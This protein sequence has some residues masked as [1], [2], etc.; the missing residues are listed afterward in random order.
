MS[1]KN[2]QTNQ[3]RDD[4]APGL[5]V[6]MRLMSLLWPKGE[7]ALKA[8]VVGALLLIVVGKGISVV[9]PFIYKHVIDSLNTAPVYAP[10]ALIVAYGVADALNQLTGELREYLFVTVSQRAIRIT[11]LDVFQKLHALSLRFHLNRRTGGVAT[12]IA[13]GTTGI[14]FLLELALFSIFPT[15]VELALVS[16]ILLRLYDPSFA[17]IIILTI[18]A[19]LG[20]TLAMTQWQVR[21]RKEMN[22]LDVAASMKA[23]DSLLNYETVKYFTAEKAEAQRFDAA[24]SAYERSAIRNQKVQVL[25]NAGR[26]LI[27]ATG[28]MS[29]MVLAGRR[30]AEGAMTVGD[31]V[32]VNAYLL[33]LYVPLQALSLVYTQIKQ[34]LADVEAMMGLLSEKPE[35]EDVPNSPGL[36]VDQGGI[37]FRNVSFH[38][39]ERR[40]L[41]RDI[42]FEIPSGKT[43]AIVGA[44]G[45]GKSTIARLL[46]RFYDVNAGEIQLDGHDIRTVTQDSL[47]NAIGV[48]PQDTV[49]FHDTLFYNIAYGKFGA[50]RQ[51]VEH[52]A[53]AAQLDQLIARLPDG[54]DTHVGERGMKL[55]GGEKQRVAIARVILKNPRVLIFD[56]ATSALD[57]ATEQE[58]LRSLNK[59]ANDRTTLVIAHRLSTIVNA[60]EI[61]VLGD[62]RIEERGNHETLVRRGGLYHDLW[63]RQQAS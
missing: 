40:P 31:F 39:D 16:A 4:Q 52:A 30:V 44:S 23:I 36:R 13:R 9:A 14:E 32:L 29:V 58:I 59:I 15:F 28:A 49:L 53:S 45:V 25:F 55:S 62:G 21:Y 12:V 51:D 11:S 46:F 8:R 27:I 60:D 54:F 41:L 24:K 43:V 50:S 33:Q 5:Q 10:I 1:I 57:S 47:R 3:S 48:V 6:A 7:N 22:K 17:I 37:S 38:Y 35:I 56:E 63:R 20:F 34:S 19:Y 61:L 42:S 2:P 18:T 26:S